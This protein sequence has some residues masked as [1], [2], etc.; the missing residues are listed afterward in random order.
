MALRDY[1]KGKYLL[2]NRPGQLLP[3]G[4]TKDVVASKA[5][6]QQQQRILEKVWKNIEK[7][8]GEMKNVLLAQLQDSNKTVEEQEKTLEQVPVF[9]SIVIPLICCLLRILL[10]L[11]SNDDPI[12]KYFDIHHG[13]ILNSMQQAYR[14]SLRLVDGEF[15]GAICR[16]NLIRVCFQRQ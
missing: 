6:E 8:M 4:S 15:D 7:A 1:K 11:Q 3:I 10:E 9:M 14:S 5:A 12:W 2:E 16:S 13:Q